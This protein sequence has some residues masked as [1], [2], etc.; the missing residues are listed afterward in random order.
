MSG[1]SLI[2]SF[3]AFFVRLLA[4]NNITGV[5]CALL[6]LNVSLAV[7]L[8]LCGSTQYR[9][10]IWEVAPHLAWLFAILQLL[11]QLFFKEIVTPR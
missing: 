5:T 3:C 2:D 1:D 6:V 9:G 7:F 4:R 8:R 10:A 11:L